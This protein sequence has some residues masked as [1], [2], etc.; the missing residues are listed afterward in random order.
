M[1]RLRQDDE[2]GGCCPFFRRRRGRGPSTPPPPSSGP[3]NGSREVKLQ[4]N[5]KPAFAEK[6]PPPDQAVGETVSEKP[7][8]SPGSGPASLLVGSIDSHGGL[9][10]RQ[11]NLSA[12]YG[13]SLRRLRAERNFRGAAAKLKRILPLD[14]NAFSVPEGIGLQYVERVDD[15]EEEAKRIEVAIEGLIHERTQWRPSER[16]IKIWIR[17]WFRASF[18]FVK[19]AFKT[20]G[21]SLSARPPL[22][23]SVGNRTQSVRSRD[24]CVP[25]LPAGLTPGV[26]GLLS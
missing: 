9:G 24:K 25:F 14:P 18:P 17:D 2:V 21:V 1:P 10:W 15:V 5:S 13:P 19:V 16:T 20:V 26:P 3:T 7:L 6:V 8:K 22:I 23:A 12:A 11:S 4:P